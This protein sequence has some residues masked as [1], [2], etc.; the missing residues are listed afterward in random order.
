MPSKL[1]EFR[2]V[3]REC[4]RTYKT[5][6]TVAP[7]GRLLSRALCRYVDSGENGKSASPRRILEVGPGTGPVTRWIVEAMGAGDLLDI[8]ELNDTFVEVLSRRFE[9][10]PAFQAV[11]SRCRILH[12]P[13]QE[14]DGAE[15]YDVII[16]GLPLNNF[17]V[18]EVDGI[19]ELFSRLAAPRATVSF[20]EYIGNRKVKASISGH[21]QR[22]RVR[23]VAKS[24][25]RFL[26]NEIHRD[27]VLGNVPPAWVHHVQ[28]HGSQAE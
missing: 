24:V 21:R 7:S 5:T 3:L 27:R 20:F 19:L 15:P 8:V 26:R 11:E 13:V 28:P 10:E 4:R 16:S 9:Q 14:L 1:S 22:S 12:H 6:G 25:E 17:E 2:A 23:G 18:H